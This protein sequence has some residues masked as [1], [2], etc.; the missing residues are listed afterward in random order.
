MKSYLSSDFT[1]YGEF[2]FLAK[3]QL[4]DT[5]MGKA[6]ALA[7]F[8]DPIG[9]PSKCATRVQFH[10]QV[11]IHAGCVADAADGSK[12]KISLRVTS[13]A[14]LTGMAQAW[15]PFLEITANYVRATLGLTGFDLLKD[16][17]VRPSDAELMLA[18]QNLRLELGKDSGTVVAGAHNCA[19]GHGYET[20][21]CTGDP[22]VEANWLHAASSSGSTHVQLPG[23]TPGHLVYVRMRAIY[24]KKGPGAWSD[25]ASIMVA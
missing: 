7:A 8:P 9:D 22:G 2:A 19:G 15:I 23:L 4:I 5:S 21:T 24:G 12:S 10:D 16:G 25:I 6:A 3:M 17:S 13:R 18:P 14:T 20:Q 1:K 11:V